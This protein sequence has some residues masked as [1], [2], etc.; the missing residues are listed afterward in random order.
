MTPHFLAKVRGAVFFIKIKILEEF[1]RRFD[2]FEE[3]YS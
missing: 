1:A 2:G 3:I